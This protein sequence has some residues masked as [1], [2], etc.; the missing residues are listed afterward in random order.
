VY[1]LQ[2]LYVKA[3][4]VCLNVKDYK[5]AIFLLR[6]LVKYVSTHFIVDL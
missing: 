6:V 2:D 3:M 5:N 4:S 1:I